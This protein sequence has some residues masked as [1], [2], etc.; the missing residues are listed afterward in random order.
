[1][2]LVLRIA[3]ASEVTHLP[4]AVADSHS[5]RRYQA[6][7]FGGQSLTA[8]DIAMEPIVANRRQLYSKYL[9]SHGLR[10]WTLDCH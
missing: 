6:E 2:G 5:W 7:R 8:S 1:M 9:G 3:E 10:A 4:R